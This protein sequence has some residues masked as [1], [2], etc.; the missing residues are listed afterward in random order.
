[1]RAADPSQ[2]AGATRQGTA[3]IPASGCSDAAAIG[4]APVPVG[5]VVV[6]KVTG[7]R[8]AGP[9]AGTVVVM[10][11]KVAGT[12]VVTTSARRGMTRSVMGPVAAGGLAAALETAAAATVAAVALEETVLVGG[13]PIVVPRTFP[14]SSRLLEGC[15]VWQPHGA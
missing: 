2:G 7:L 10:V 8:I 3:P 5:T 13:P 14:A 9:V 15:K 6:V 4:M 11:A 1:M 12:G